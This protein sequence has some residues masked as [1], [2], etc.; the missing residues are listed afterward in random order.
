[1]SPRIGLATCEEAW[2]ED[3]DAPPIE[4]AFAD[5]GAS[6]DW[7]VWDDP[8]VEWAAYDLVVVR[9]T[10]DYVPRREEFLG[11]ADRV[12]AAT[13]LENGPAVLR[14]NTDKH[15]LDDL[16]AAGVPT[17]PTTFLDPDR[18][19]A[20]RDAV[21]AA[22]PAD[23]GFVVKPAVSAGSK[24]TVR[25]DDGPRER[26]RAVAQASDLLA[27]GRS[28]VVQPY[29]AAV[30][31][32][33]ETGLVHVGGAFSH[34]FRKGPLLEVGGAPVTALYARES[35]SPRTATADELAV[36]AAAVAAAEDLLGTRL[37]YARIDLLPGD[38]GRPL[39][40]ELELSEPSFFLDTDPGAA[41]RAV[42]AFLRAAA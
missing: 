16:A 14:W 19:H 28:V 40:L 17:V 13:R 9:S 38:D 24:D 30:D 10:W 25:Y 32:L 7:L 26:E 37:L 42:D 39:L 27:S 11:W 31:E 29:L 2:R 6:F 36:G 12:A 8:T 20:S 34:A 21:P 15:Y 22:L 3:E 1:M 4:Q 41:G 23:G 35:I 5:R 33:G 18:G